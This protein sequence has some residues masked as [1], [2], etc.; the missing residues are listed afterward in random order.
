MID[1]CR[2]DFPIRMMCRHLSVSASG[3][4]DWHGRKPSQRTLANEKLLSRIEELHADSDGVMGAP[5]IWE[6]LRYEGMTCSKNRV[7]RLERDFNAK[8]PNTKWVTDITYIR[9]AEG[10]LY[11]CVVLDLCDGIIIGWSMSHRQT[12]DMVLRAVL[13]AL[14]QRKDND[15]VNLPAMSISIF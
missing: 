8:Q 10:W 14:W 7:A 12:R 9:T 5:R 3:Y 6:D 11:F 1:R 2:E 15:P 4:Y 13:M